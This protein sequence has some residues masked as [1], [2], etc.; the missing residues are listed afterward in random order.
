LCSPDAGARR[1]GFIK[2]GADAPYVPHL[3]VETDV[4]FAKGYRMHIYWDR[5]IDKAIPQI[6][7]L[8]RN[9]LSAHE[10]HCRERGQHRSRRCDFIMPTT[11]SQ[12]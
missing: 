7:T 9:F 5:M 6:G 8:V 11:A 12:S 10:G 3:T 2:D 4:T 1:D